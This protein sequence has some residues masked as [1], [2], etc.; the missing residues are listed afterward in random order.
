MT[1]FDAELSAIREKANQ[2][3]LAH[4]KALAEIESQ[5][6]L[7]A[8]GMEAL[9]LFGCDTVDEAKQ[10]I[11]EIRLSVEKKTKEIEDLLG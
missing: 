2:A 7:Y 1:A 3:Q 6:K 9:K 11:E 4:A 5:Q 10:K 8:Q